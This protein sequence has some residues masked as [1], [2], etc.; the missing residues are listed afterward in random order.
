MI[1]SSPWP[2]RR[3]EGEEEASTPG[4]EFRFRSSALMSCMMFSSVTSGIS[5][6]CPVEVE[7]VV[8][9][10]LDAVSETDALVVVVVVEGRRVPAPATLAVFL[11]LGGY[12]GWL[13]KGGRDGNGRPLPLNG[14]PGRGTEILST[15][16][17]PWMTT[18][19]W[20]ETG[21][22]SL[23]FDKSTATAATGDP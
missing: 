15:G 19:F 17:P 3:P 2:E 21:L 9:G 10:L 16:T 18:G 22:D 20:P 6:E 23:S 4:L 14:L 8:V 13:R 12:S 7:W 5:V 11:G 1:R